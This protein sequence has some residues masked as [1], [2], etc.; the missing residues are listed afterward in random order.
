MLPLGIA[1]DH[2]AARPGSTGVVARSAPHERRH[3]GL[4]IVCLAEQPGVDRMKKCPIS[5]PVGFFVCIGVGDQRWRPKGRTPVCSP[6]PPAHSPC[7]W[8][9]PVTRP[10]RSGTRPSLSPPADRSTADLRR[11]VPSRQ[12]SAFPRSP[13]CES[14]RRHRG[15]GHVQQERH[16][17]GTRCR[18]R[19]RVGSQPCLLADSR[20]HLDAEAEVHDIP[21]NPC[22]AAISE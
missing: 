7:S 4:K 10:A 12:A 15:G 5:I 1:R 13:C 18:E 17:V 14:G 2:H 3:I 20:R 21:T 22:F 16:A 11:P 8:S 9:S 19:P 6:S